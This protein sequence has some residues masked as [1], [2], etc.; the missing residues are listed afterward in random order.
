M[1]M[2]T[3]L[4]FAENHILLYA[5]CTR[6]IY[7]HWACYLFEFVW[8]SEL[9]TNN[10]PNL[11]ASMFQRIFESMNATHHIGDIISDE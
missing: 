4:N 11:S 9:G 7:I 10:W 2:S 8:F 1:F 6:S 5:I 3:L